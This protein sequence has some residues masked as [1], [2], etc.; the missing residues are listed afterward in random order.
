M[1]ETITKTESKESLKAEVA[2]TIKCRALYPFADKPVGEADT[3]WG[4]PFIHEVVKQ[5]DGDFHILTAELPV[6]VAKEMQAAGR[7]ERV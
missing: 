4:V 7:V 2:K 5:K 6:D 1:T 3:I